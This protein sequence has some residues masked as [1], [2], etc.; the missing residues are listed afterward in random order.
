MSQTARRLTLHGGKVSSASTRYRGCPWK[1]GSRNSR[2]FMNLRRTDSN[3]GLNGRN[4]LNCLNSRGFGQQRVPLARQT[5]GTV[6]HMHLRSRRILTGRYRVALMAADDR[7]TVVRIGSIDKLLHQI[8]GKQ[9]L[10]RHRHDG[11]CFGDHRTQFA[12]LP[13]TH[14]VR[15][16]LGPR[17]GPA[18]RL[19]ASRRGQFLS[20]RGAK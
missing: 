16:P 6:I 14:S 11:D 15:H 7:Q 17:A 8:R 4:R 10:H 18:L 3:A 12:I 1:L 13:I 19:V 5:A 2:D 9:D 20:R